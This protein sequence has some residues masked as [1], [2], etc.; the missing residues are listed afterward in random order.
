MPIIHVNKSTFISASNILGSAG[1]SQYNVD[2][3]QYKV[4]VIHM[5]EV[6]NIVCGMRDA[7]VVFVN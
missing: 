6:I 1:V 7:N 3:C 5:A 2:M 4:V